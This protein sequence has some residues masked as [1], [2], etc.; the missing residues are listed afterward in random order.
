[1]VYHALAMNKKRQ[2]TRDRLTG[3]GWL[4]EDTMKLKKTDGRFTGHLVY[5]Y[6]VD[7]TLATSFSPMRPSPSTVN[8]AVH[9]RKRL[10]EVRNWCW[11]T[12]GPGCELDTALLLNHDREEPEWCWRTEH[13]QLRIYLKAKNAEWFTLKWT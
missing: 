12:F 8:R 13:N 3:W 9:D 2:M 1:M 6:F 4:F 7:F 5:E 11:E 10:N